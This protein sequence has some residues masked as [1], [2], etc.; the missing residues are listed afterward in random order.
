MDLIPAVVES[1]GHGANEGLH[2]RRRL[3]IARPESTPH[4]LVIQHLNGDQ[5]C[6]IRRVDMV[7]RE[8]G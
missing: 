7:L 6:L 3:I 4:V 8:A 2:P 5:E 1:H